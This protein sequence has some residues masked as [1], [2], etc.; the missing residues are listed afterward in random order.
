MKSH[1]LFYS[2]PNGQS[3]RHGFQDIKYIEVNKLMATSR[4]F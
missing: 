3:I 1:I 2:R 4:P